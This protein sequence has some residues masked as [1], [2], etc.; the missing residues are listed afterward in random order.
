MKACELVDCQNIV[1]VTNKLIFCKDISLFL[2]YETFKGLF[3]GVKDK[4]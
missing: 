2:S 3:Q 4:R 1:E